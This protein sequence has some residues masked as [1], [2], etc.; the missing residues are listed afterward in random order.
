[1]I[2]GSLARTVSEGVGNVKG[3]QKERKRYYHL[4]A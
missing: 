1:M 4:S 2:E 3:N